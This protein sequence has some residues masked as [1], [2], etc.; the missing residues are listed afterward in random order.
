[1]TGTD[2]VPGS[3]DRARILDEATL[4]A[5]VGGDE[6]LKQQLIDLFLGSYPRL[7]ARIR[8]AV[9][10]RDP[11]K[12]RRAADALKSSATTVSAAGVVA[13][14]VTMESLGA[15]ERLSG[16]TGALAALEREIASL[17]DVLN[18]LK[19]NRWP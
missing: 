8:D 19:V 18:T 2:R 12:L 17:L 1:M 4:S 14:T 15:N 6:R 9:A 7:I 13:A 11:V 5:T 10:E 3:N 16:A